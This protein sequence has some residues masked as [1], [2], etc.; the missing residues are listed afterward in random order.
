M[1]SDSATFIVLL[2][3][4][5]YAMDITHIEQDGNTALAIKEGIK[6]FKFPL[7]ITMAPFEKLVQE[8]KL[9]VDNTLFIKD[10]LSIS[11]SVLLVC[12]HSLGKSTLLTMLKT[13]L[14]IEVDENG[15]TIT[16]IEARRNYRLFSQGEIVHDNGTIETLKTPLMI[17]KYKKYFDLY[18][19]KY[20]VIYL[21]LR[22]A[23]GENGHDVR[24]RMAYS[25]A[26]AYRDHQYMIPVLQKKL[27]ES[28]S[29]T[30]HNATLQD[31]QN[32]QKFVYFN[33]SYK[34]YP[35]ELITSVQKLRMLLWRHHHRQSFVLIDDYDSPIHSYMKFPE[36]HDMDA[37]TTINI[38]QSFLAASTTESKEYSCFRSIAT[39]RFSLMLPR[40]RHY[41]TFDIAN[42]NHPL[43]EYFGFKERH[44]QFLYRYINLTEKLVD[45]AR[46]W[47][48]GYQSPDMPHEIYN[49]KSIVRF[50]TNQ[51]ITC[52]RTEKRFVK[53]MSELFVLEPLYKNRI[54]DLISTGEFQTHQSEEQRECVNVNVLFLYNA[55]FY[56]PSPDVIEG[57]LRL[58]F[59]LVKTELR[60]KETLA[61]KT[62]TVI[63]KEAQHI[64]GDWL[65]WHYRRL[66]AIS[67]SSVDETAHHFLAFIR[68]Q[69][70]FV[71]LKH[72]MKALYRSKSYMTEEKIPDFESNPGGLEH[73][74]LSILNCVILRSQA[75]SWFELDAY[76]KNI[77]TADVVLYDHKTQ[78]GVVVQVRQFYRTANRTFK[79]AMDHIHVLEFFPNVRNRLAIGI[80]VA[81]NRS[82][83]FLY[84]NL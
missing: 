66:Y 52:Y 31:L 19:G 6:D 72:H 38:L 67:D 57:K 73:P 14:E 63:N 18:Q 79:S 33:S 17:S 82:V 42:T 21:S 30:E 37:F 43:R 74:A 11:E 4:T 81:L 51:R 25:V 61:G 1:A 46:Q 50:V 22:N 28:L 9:F 13:F 60:I 84:R 20:V 59:P 76:Y 53:I 62:R 23:I 10:I 12:P 75:L 32:F 3:S 83:Q 45:Q 55:K 70:S 80:N 35:N 48:G 65:I 24:R 78:T 15:E 34:V 69:S 54:F 26:R 2:L 27:N 7:P 29:P 36:F 40:W 44:I 58:F 77:K 8:S 68:N 49:S 47:Y 39:G 41:S 64:I 5:V 71:V 56:N 16:Q